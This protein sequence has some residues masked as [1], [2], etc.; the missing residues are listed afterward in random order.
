MIP[1]RGSSSLPNR[2]TTSQNGRNFDNS[3]MGPIASRAA[4]VSARLASTVVGS[5]IE[6]G[7]GDAAWLALSDRQ[8]DYAVSDGALA[9]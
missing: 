4:R 1:S 9:S 7:V 3:S 2:K 6:A 8:L 5:P